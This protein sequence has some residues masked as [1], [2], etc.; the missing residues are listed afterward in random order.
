METYPDFADSFEEK[1]QVTFDLR[2]CELSEQKPT[3]KK[4]NK[5]SKGS[6]AAAAAAKRSSKASSKSGA[7]LPYP[8]TSN[9]SVTQ[10]S[11]NLHASLDKPSFQIDKSADNDD[12]IE[13]KYLRSSLS[14]VK[15]LDSTPGDLSMNASVSRSASFWIQKQRSVNSY[16]S[17]ASSGVMNVTNPTRRVSGILRKKSR[18]IRNMARLVPTGTT[19]PKL[20]SPTGGSGGGGETKTIMTGVYGAQRQSSTFSEVECEIDNITA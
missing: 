20:A 19:P 2:E 11:V 7:H 15:R 10:P 5:A 13:Q 17:A 12:T 9:V 8:S 3:K 16:G 6:A 14:S 1:F 4:M 18:I